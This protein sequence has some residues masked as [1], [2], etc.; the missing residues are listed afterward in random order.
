LKE[1]RKVKIGH[2]STKAGDGWFLDK[3]VVKPVNDPEKTTEFKC[4]RWLDVKEDDG[5]IVRELTAGGG[6]QM[7]N[8]KC[9]FKHTIVFVTCFSSLGCLLNQ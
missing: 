7:L 1:L 2:N 9:V 3:V 4:G 5:L 8:S 6:P